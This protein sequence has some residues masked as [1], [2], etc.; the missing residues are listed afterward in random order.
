[1]ALKLAKT[2]LLKTR[3]DLFQ[4]ALNA[5]YSAS[6]L[7]KIGLGSQ[8]TLNW[9]GDCGHSWPA[10]V[11]D[12]STR[13]TGCPFC[14]GRS[15]LKGFNDLQ[16]RFPEVASQ[17]HPSLNGQLKPDEVSAGSH[18]KAWWMGSCGHVWE[19]QI[20][21]RALG[22]RG[23]G[24]C[25][26]R[27]VLA[28]FNDLATTHP[29]LAK[30]VSKNSSI[31]AEEI[32]FGSQKVVLWNFGCGHE[33]DAQV[34]EVV[35]GARCPYC[36]GHRLKKGFNDL[37]TRYPKL[38]KEW[39]Q[40]KNGKLKPSDVSFASAKKVFWSGSCGHTWQAVISNRSKLGHGC[41]ICAGKTVISGVNDIATVFPQ[42]LSEWDFQQNE[43]M[44]SQLSWGTK[45]NLHFLC[46]L[47]H[48]Y[49]ANP[50]TKVKRRLGCPY[51]AFRKLLEGFNDFETVCPDAA[52]EWDFIKND[53]KPSDFLPGSQNK[54]WFVCDKGHSWI[55][56]LFS[57]YHTK[58]GCPSCAE[59]GFNPLK[60]GAI[61]FLKHESLRSFKVGITNT[62]T[63]QDR[64]AAFV[65]R[66]WELIH[67]W[68]IDQGYVAYES[69]QLFF[70][71]LRNEICLPPSCTKEELQGMS[72]FTETFT[73]GVISE[74]LVK[75]K[76]GKII[77]S[78]QSS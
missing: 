48:S 25:T 6:E 29:H 58:T 55:A 60:P 62:G 65:S 46:S 67:K 72:G 9:K 10:R 66:N 71:W 74:A 37:E 49:K 4:Q 27:S 33:F 77:A 54:F 57:R 50:A 69:E 41:S 76:I 64:I 15:L 52:R 63:R 61:Y 34:T 1:V 70:Y 22:S 30:N 18:A 23:C 39:N 16:T 32:T 44:P 24:Y 31:S 51:C 8:I 28:G 59:T 2:P 40:S 12:R 38:S 47:G 78:N 3:M 11:K 75:S 20:K 19:A 73:M 56:S 35:R 53:S 14:S 21:S 42:L 26:G 17:W 7:S 5:G 45:S 68:D 13:G 43:I 36:S